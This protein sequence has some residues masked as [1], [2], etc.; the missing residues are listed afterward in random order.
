MNRTVVLLVGRLLVRTLVPAVAVTVTLA[1]PAPV[2]AEEPGMEQIEEARERYNAASIAFAEGRFA[3]AESAFRQVYG[4]L[5]TPTLL[6]ETALAQQKQ[7][8]WRDAANSFTAYL[9]DDPKAGPKKRMRIDRQVVA[10]RRR[11]D[12]KDKLDAVARTGRQIPAPSKQQQEED[13]LLMAFG[14]NDSDA[15]PSP[16]ATTATTADANAAPR[17]VPQ[18]R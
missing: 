6:F 5:R 7:G 8:K 11:A 13:R 16:T 10:L 18:K 14:A 15:A 3:D 2:H 12:W 9:R 1:A 4:V 17:P